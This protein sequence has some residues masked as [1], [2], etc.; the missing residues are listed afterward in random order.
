MDAMLLD[1]AVNFTKPD[2]V[3]RAREDIERQFKPDTITIDTFFHSSVGA[4]LGEPSEVLTI[5]A[6]I[7]KFLA[8][9]KAH[10]TL[11]VHHTPKDG[12]GFWGS[13]ILEGTADAMI[14]C[15][16][17][18]EIAD[19]ATLSCE[20]MKGGRKFAPI[21][22]TLKTRVIKTLPDEDGIDE[23]EQLV[24]V[25]GTP[26]PKKQSREDEDLDM[27]IFLLVSFLGNRATRGQWVKE[28]QKYATKDGKRA[29]GWSD[30][31]IDRKIDKLLRQGRIAGGGG[32][33]EYYSAVDTMRAEAGIQPGAGNGVGSGTGAD[34]A[35]EPV[36]NAAGV[37]KPSANY[38][39]RNPQGGIAGS[40]GGFEGPASTRKAPAN[41]NAGG[42][43]ESR[44]GPD[45][46]VAMT[47]LEK[48]VWKNLKGENAKH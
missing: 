10:T 42:S 18:E 7:E 37:E 33:G 17:N 39:H 3:E 16:T 23:V 26:A 9:L 41:E 30:D 31:S 40:A 47:D 19:T 36:E 8:D 11:L 1:R 27:M 21:D 24:V 4:N 32:Q 20:R 13:V 48:E 38:P 12:K 2:E 46:S 14:H 22:I 6:R 43:S 28:I 5:V 45:S 29:R 15:E 44:T 34:D 35:A 25:S